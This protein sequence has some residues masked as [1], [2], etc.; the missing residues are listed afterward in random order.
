[1]ASTTSIIDDIR[2]AARGVAGLIVGDRKAAGYFDF[3]DRGLVTS[4]IAFLVVTAAN[5][6]LPKLLG[7]ESG[8]IFRSIAMVAILFVFQIG[9]TVIVLRQL[10]RLDGLVPYLVADNWATF[11]I[12]IGSTLL[13]LAGLTGDVAIIAIGLAVIIVEINIARLIV[14]LSPLQIAMLLIAQLVGVSIG[15]LVVGMVLPLSP[16]EQAALQSLAG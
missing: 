5:A 6:A 2:L 10:K 1:L 13:A 4:F 16:A 3:S 9:F 11:F 12:T 15:L 8:P 14:T 7:M